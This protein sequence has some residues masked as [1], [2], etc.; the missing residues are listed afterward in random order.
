MSKQLADRGLRNTEQSGGGRHAAGTHHGPEDFHLP[1][2][3]H[4]SPS[5][6][7]QFRG[8]SSPRSRI[9]QGGPVP[10]QHLPNEARYRGKV[11]ENCGGPESKSAQITPPALN[12][13]I[14]SSERPARSRWPSS[15]SATSGGLGKRMGRAAGRG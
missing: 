7:F 14:P 6:H 8:T 10:G 4:A 2:V 9:R 3:Q 11:A 13:A 5:R 15:L 12:A 1:D